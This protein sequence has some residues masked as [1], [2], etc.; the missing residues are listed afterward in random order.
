MK[1]E[2]LSDTNSDKENDLMA[3]EDVKLKK[4]SGKEPVKKYDEDGQSNLS[5]INDKSTEY[6]V[7]EMTIEMVSD[8]AECQEKAEIGE[9]EAEMADQNSEGANRVNLM[10][11]PIQTHINSLENFYYSRSL[12]SDLSLF[13]ALTLQPVFFGRSVLDWNGAN[14]C[15]SLL[16]YCSASQ[17]QFFNSY[18]S[19]ANILQNLGFSATTD[20]ADGAGGSSSS[21]APDKRKDAAESVAEV[22]EKASCSFCFDRYES[23]SCL[24]YALHECNAPLEASA[25]CLCCGGDEDDDDAAEEPDEEPDRSPNKVLNVNPGWFGKGCRKKVKKRK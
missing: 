16:P 11:V 17:S 24:F 18:F 23:G 1:K 7:P 21:S 15:A 22:A 20:D 14:S 13:D 8:S 9:D 12:W 25:A 3:D 19:Y 2:S 4:S 5:V 10:S 6:I